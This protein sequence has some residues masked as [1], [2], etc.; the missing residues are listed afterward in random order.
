MD[1]NKP[2]AAREKPA[3][4]AAKKAAKTTAKPAAPAADAVTEAAPKRRG[5][6]P[7]AKTTV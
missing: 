2:A 6:P 3:K 4:P 7:K 1:D 5:R